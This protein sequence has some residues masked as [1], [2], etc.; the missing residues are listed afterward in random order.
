MPYT[1]A[2]HQ[3]SR[4]SESGSPRSA[5]I[6]YAFLL[7]WIFSDFLNLFRLRVDDGVRDS[8]RIFAGQK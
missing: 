3:R 5:S 2:I 7:W 8:Q 1:L 4:H 6:Q